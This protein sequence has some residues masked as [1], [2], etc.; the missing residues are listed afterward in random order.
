MVYKAIALFSLC[1]ALLGVVLPGLPTTPFLLSA[2][3][4]ARRGWPAFEQYLQT[5]PRFGPLLQQW[6]QHRVV[7]RSAKYTASGML[8]VS[9]LCLW[10]WQGLEWALAGSVV[11]VIGLTLLW[12]QPEGVSP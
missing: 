6:Q 8:G 7:P 4:A 11:V 5:H 3:W 12:R 1:L 10:W 9:L 2:S